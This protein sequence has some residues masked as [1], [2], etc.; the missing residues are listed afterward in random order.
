[1]SHPIANPESRRLSERAGRTIRATYDAARTTDDNRRHW[2][3]ADGL[4]AKAANNVG[5]RRILRTR[6]RYEVANN[7][8]LTGIVATKGNDTVGT[9]PTLQ[10]LTED[11]DGNSR[12]EGSFAE[13]AKEVDLARK[14]RT[15][16][17]TSCVGGEVFL[18][19]VYNPRLVHPV[20]L[21][22]E[23]YEGDQFTDPTW[24]SDSNPLWCDGIQFDA[25]GNPL[26][27]RRLKWHPGDLTWGANPMEF[28]DL[29][30]RMVWHHFNH[31]PGRTGQKRGIPEITPSLPNWP[32]LRR[33]CEA[34]VA[35]AETAADNAMS[36]ESDTPA[37]DPADDPEAMDVVELRRRMATVL[38]KGYKLNQTKAEQP[39]TTYGAFTDKKVAEGARCINMPFT[40]AA[41]DSSNANLSARYLDSQIYAKGVKIDRGQIDR[42]LDRILDLFLTEALHLPEPIV[43]Q[44]IDAFPHKWYWPKVVEH[45][46]PDKVASAQGQRMKIGTSTYADE[47]AEEGL[48]WEEV[49]EKGARSLGIPVEEFQ[50]RIRFGIWGMAEDQAADA[51]DPTANPADAA[52]AAAAARAAEPLNGAQITAAIDVLVK[53]REQTL[54][55]EAVKELLVKIGFDDATAAAIVKNTPIGLDNAA[56]DAQFKREVFKQL[57]AVP[58][59]REAIYNGVDILDLITK[60]GLTPEPGYQAPYA[61]VVAP[62]GPLT[63]GE[64]IEDPQGD[65]VGADVLGQLEQAAA[66]VQQGKRSRPGSP[67]AATPA[68]DDAAADPP[69]PGT[70]GAPGEGEAA[71]AEAGLFSRLARRLAWFIRAEAPAVPTLEEVLADW[72]TIDDHPVYIDEGGGGGG[73]GGSKGGSDKGSHGGGGG[74]HNSGG[75]GGGKGGGGGHD[76]LTP[77]LKIAEQNWTRQASKLSK[78]RLQKALADR[79][80]FANKTPNAVDRLIERIIK[81]ELAKRK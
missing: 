60:T 22:V 73:G 57:L 2:A 49:Q 29:P 56:G 27:Y 67:A 66:A 79:A 38:P 19:F 33:Y 44:G 36:I 7:S 69:S 9:G 34:V 18:V 63:S 25:Y 47:C 40:I 71:K 53:L 61:A 43:P 55:P 62:I 72:V 75:G 4:S 28:E 1:M 17:T 12:M 35:A 6:A 21:D 64:T 50:R 52:A 20:K 3:A 58:Q 23:L 70:A 11:R 81:D 59:A 46:D 31:M 5:V 14:L 76:E 24:Q 45:A 54:T 42:G 16:V 32:D 15:L 39:T 41:L 74:G 68:A 10:M 77:D 48:D 30:A 51:A 65:T 13:W 37:D 78:P 80:K 8:T 26:S